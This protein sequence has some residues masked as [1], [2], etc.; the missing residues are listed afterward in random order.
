MFKKCYRCEYNLPLF[1]FYTN[2]TKHKIA[3]DKGKT[4]SCR[5]CTAKQ[6]RDCNGE[7][8]RLNYETKKFYILKLEPT[9]LNT[10]RIFFKNR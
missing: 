7:V 5:F 10:L 4:V 9:I 8:V 2:H 3:S 1:L 6:F